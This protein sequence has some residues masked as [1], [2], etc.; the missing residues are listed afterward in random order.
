MNRLLVSRYQKQSSEYWYTR[1]EGVIRGPFSAE[2]I[3]RHILLGR[4]HLDDELSQDRE[5]WSVAGHVANLLPSGPRSQSSSEADER[6]SERRCQDCNN[7][8]DHNVERRILP[9]RRGEDGN[10]VLSHYLNEKVVSTDRKCP[11]ARYLRP[12]LLTVLL[13]A[14]VFAWLYPTQS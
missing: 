11:E 7:Y 4:V 2:N 9:D 12:L 1:R 6:K 13:A 8:P 10:T 3:S 14:L 5:N